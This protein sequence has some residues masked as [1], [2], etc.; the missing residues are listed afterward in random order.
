MLIFNHRPFC[1]WTDMSKTELKTTPLFELHQELGA[2]L[3]P[4]AGYSMPLFYPL[5]V[6]NEHNHTREKAGLFDISHMVHMEVTGANA[7]KAIARACPLVPS[8]FEDGE[9]RYTFFLN[10]EAGVEDDL[11]VTKLAD[12]RFLLVTN[13]GC[14]DKDIAH[15]KAICESLGATHT[16]IPRGFIALQGPKAEQAMLDLGYDLTAIAFMHGIETSSGWFISRSGYTGEDGFEIAMGEDEIADFTKKLL[17]HDD[18]EIIG[19]GARD[20]LRLE[21]GLSLY[22]QDL[23][24]TTTPSEAGLI[25]AIPKALREGGEFIGADALTVKL[26]EGRKRKRVG[27]KPEGKMPVR[28]GADIV[29]TAG[30][31][32]GKVTSGGFGPTFGGPVAL[33]LIPANHE[34]EL[35][36]SVRGKQI[37]LAVHPLPFTP[38]NFKR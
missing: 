32:I 19:L 26:A 7:E 5:G 4:F 35:F 25:W 36:A 1:D 29:N 10:E 37:P 33:G 18:V 6:M 17:D 8:S 24:E 34:G 14:A 31:T 3:G 38:H 23:D 28:A 2:K 21:A 16:V 11:I 12:E 30:D 27:L 9:C 20:S 22:S 13:A 15:M